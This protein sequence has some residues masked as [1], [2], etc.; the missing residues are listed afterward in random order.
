MKIFV[1]LLL[2]KTQQAKKISIK[3]LLYFSNKFL[4]FRSKI[5][6]NKVK[7]QNKTHKTNLLKPPKVKFNSS[8]IDYQFF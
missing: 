7:F 6:I 3:M 5:K 8:S 1:F 4:K 2:L